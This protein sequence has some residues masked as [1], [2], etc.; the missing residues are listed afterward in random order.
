M[1]QR[2]DLTGRTVIITGGGKGIGKVYA[3]EFAKVGANVVVADID[4]AAAKAVA[5]AIAAS[6][7]AAFGL[8]IDIADE[9][10]THAMAKTALDRYGAIDVLVNNA[11]LMSVLPRRSWLEIP[12]EEWD[13]VMAVNLRGTFLCCRAVFPDMDAQ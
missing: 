10:A 2:F 9:D 5:D 6:G 1:N 11:S 13:R 3:Q 4:E 8:G 12:A 7:G